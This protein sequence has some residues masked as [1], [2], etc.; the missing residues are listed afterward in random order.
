MNTPH[1]G[2]L[3]SCILADEDKDQI[4]T[5][6]DQFATIQLDSELIKDVKNI[7]HGVYSP[8]AGFLKQL[9]FES[10]MHEEPTKPEILLEPH[11]D[12]IEVSVQKVISYLEENEYI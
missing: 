6:L 3:V 8:L 10:V 12:P 7:A 2:K 1:G 5:K 11:K 4:L 9:D